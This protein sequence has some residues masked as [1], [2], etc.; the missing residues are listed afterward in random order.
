MVW[1]FASADSSHSVLS[2][3]EEEAKKLE[4]ENKS[5]SNGAVATVNGTSK[6]VAVI[7]TTA[8]KDLGG[9]SFEAVETRK[10]SWHMFKASLSK[11]TQEKLL[12]VTLV[13]VTQY[14][15]SWLQ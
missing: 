10:S 1:I 2:G 3:E 13:T 5:K 7:D 12:T 8:A 6:S 11:A 4:E 9:F 14:R 15:A